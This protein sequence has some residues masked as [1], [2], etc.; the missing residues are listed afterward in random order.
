MNNLQ[1]IIFI[2]VFFILWVFFVVLRIRSL[3]QLRNFI[4]AISP[5]GKARMLAEYMSILKVHSSFFN[6]LSEAGKKNFVTRCS[7]FIVNKR[8]IGMEGLVITHEIRI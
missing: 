4:V 5:A 8:F 2:I 1:L 7:G 3:S 6:N